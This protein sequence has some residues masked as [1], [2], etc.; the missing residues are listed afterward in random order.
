MRIKVKLRVSDHIRG[1][2]TFL[3]PAEWI[4]KTLNESSDVDVLPVC[5]SGLVKLGIHC[6]TCQKVAIKIVNREKLSESVLMKVRLS[7]VVSVCVWFI[8]ICLVEELFLHGCMKTEWDA[9]SAV[10]CSVSGCSWRSSC[11]DRLLLFCYCC[12]HFCSVSTS[13]F[14]K[15]LDGAK[16]GGMSH[17]NVCQ[18]PLR[19][20]HVQQLMLVMQEVCVCFFL[21]FSGFR[22]WSWRFWFSSVWFYLSWF[23]NICVW[24]SLTL[25]HVSKYWFSFSCFLIQIVLAKSLWKYDS[26]E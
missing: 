3:N 21:L 16:S 17:I 10:S 1:F 19:M 24:Q 13:T 5:V 18:L 7:F 11:S 22:S 20:T 23:L 25:S 14:H 2:W 26:R 12:H 15:Q 8:S 6:V 4:R 9:G